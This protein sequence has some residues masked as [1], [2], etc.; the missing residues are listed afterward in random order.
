[1]KK[2]KGTDLIVRV[3]PPIALGLLLFASINN[4]ATSLSGH[5]MTVWDP[6]LY[7]CVLAIYTLMWDISKVAV[8]RD[9]ILSQFLGIKYRLKHALRWA[10]AFFGG[11]IIFGVNNHSDLFFGVEIYHLHLIFTALVILAGYKI[12]MLYPEKKKD[13]IISWF[14]LAFGMIGFGAGYFFN[15][16]SVT[17][18]EFLVALP[19]TYTMYKIL[20]K[21]KS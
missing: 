10:A 1:M 15:L 6:I 18:A 3:L 9:K 14:L 4:F 13:K 8:D 16:Y 5:H 17:W 20:G 21:K 19:I 2:L 12:V 7:A 11:V